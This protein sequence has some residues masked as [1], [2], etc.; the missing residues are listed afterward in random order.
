MTP[1]T[2]WAMERAGLTEIVTRARRVV[3]DPAATQTAKGL[4]ARVIQYCSAAS[5]V[6]EQ[7]EEEHAL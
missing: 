2:P 7:L 5:H 4:A 3:N 6:L 1:L